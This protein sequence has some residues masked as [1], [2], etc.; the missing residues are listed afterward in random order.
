MRILTVLDG[1][2]W[3]TH[4]IVGSLTELGHEV[5]H[6]VYG[7]AVGEF[8]GRARRK[9]REDKNAQLIEA[10]R[11]LQRNGGLD[12]IFCYVYDDFLLPSTAAELA[13]IGAPI[14]NLNV[15][16]ANQ[17]FRQIRTAKY[18]SYLLCAQRAH[19]RSL[20]SYGARTLYFP[21]AGRAS[22]ATTTRGVAPNA[23]ITFLGSPTPYRRHVLSLLERAGLPIAVYGRHWLTGKSVQPEHS[24]E[25]TLADV[26]N[27]GLPRLLHEGTGGVTAALASRLGPL[28]SRRV[29]LNGVSS[30][31]Q[32]GVLPDSSLAS[33]FRNSQINIGF[34]RMR[35]LGS[36]SRSDN[37]VK[38]RDFEVP[39]AGGFY[40]V[41]EAP[42]HRELFDVDREIVTWQSTEELIDK[43][44][45][46]LSHEAERLAIAAAGYRRALRDHTW[47]RRF[48]GLFHTLG[49]S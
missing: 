18:F 3:G 22:T 25:K 48:T 21:M 10:A 34:T 45:Y 36:P 44:R 33:L 24:L 37:Q 40:L 32:C 43:S 27:Y 12:L 16:M 1:E 30:A 11:K 6:H 7:G 2:P 23:P 13:G 5:H 14:V 41:E 31:A 29:S 38:L 4:H 9:E 17:W 19:M 46:Y 39:L 49:I 28:L 26:R 20:A 42:D 15:D 8:Y 35:G 47:A